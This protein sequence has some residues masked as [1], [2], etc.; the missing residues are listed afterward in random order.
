MIAHPKK[1]LAKAHREN[2]EDYEEYSDE[3]STPPKSDS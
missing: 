1:G 3:E 2:G